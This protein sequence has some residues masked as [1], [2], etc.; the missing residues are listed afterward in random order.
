MSSENHPPVVLISEH[1]SEVPKRWLAERCR[2]IECRYDNP[3]FLSHLESCDALIVRTYTMV[4]EEFLDRAANLKVIGRAGVALEN[5]DLPA[6]R[7]RGI[8][9]VH[10]PDA[11]TQAVVEFVVCLLADALRPRITLDRAVEMEEWAALRQTIFAERQMCE[12]TLGILG[13]GRI[14][15]RVAAVAGAIGMQVM[16]HDLLEIPEDL[17]AGASPVSA[18]EL[19]RGSDIITIHIDSRPANRHFVNGSRLNLMKDGV[20]FLN[21]SRGFVVDHGALADFLRS[22]PAARAMLDVHDPEPFPADSPLIPLANASLSPHLAA[23]TNTAMENMSWVVRDI[24][25]VLEGESPKY[26]APTV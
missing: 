25:R 22:H 19:F 12:H 15:S 7:A 4:N 14:G 16:Y 26:P 2:V 11:N 6:C 3:E 8:P 1:L 5:I 17:R 13:F 24:H 18:E 20:L 21:T 10:T 23:R 9:V